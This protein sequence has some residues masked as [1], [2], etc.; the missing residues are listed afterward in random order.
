MYITFRRTDKVILFV[1]HLIGYL[2]A[3]CFVFSIS[4]H[5]LFFF[6]VSLCFQGLLYIK[7]WE[8][9]KAKIPKY[10]SW[11][12]SPNRRLRSEIWWALF[13]GLYFAGNTLM[14]IVLFENEIDLTW[15]NIVFTCV[16]F[17]LWAVFVNAGGEFLHL[18]FSVKHV[19]DSIEQDKNEV[20]KLKKEVLQDL[21]S[22]HFLFNSLNTVSSVISENKA[23]SIRF[24]KE[25]SDLYGFMLSD[26]HKTVIPLKND[27]ELAKKYA[28]LLKTRL[29]DG[30]EIDFNVPSEYDNCLL[31]P[32]TVQNLVENCAKHNVVS[33]RSVL[34]ISIYV[35]GG[36]L[37]VKNNLNL[38]M[39]SGKGSTNLGLNYICSQIEQLSD[40]E[41]VID[42]TR[43]LFVVKI[44]LIYKDTRKSLQ[45]GSSFSRNK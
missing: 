12:K 16:T 39:N 19:Q 26:S 14:S 13:T 32:M 20:I 43:E 4:F 2:V 9:F 38:K 29:E 45:K 35:D 6:T 42:K 21:I 10:A 27:I 31:P 1:Y 18:I 25:L 28:F 15:K 40:Q 37:V 36:Y 44:P 11:S 34:R 8:Q 33:K 7:L 30:V 24:V 23:K 5:F 41:V 22:P 3:V 17:T